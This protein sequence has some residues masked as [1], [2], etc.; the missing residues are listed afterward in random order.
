MKNFLLLTLVVLCIISCVQRPQ[1]AEHRVAISDYSNSEISDKSVLPTLKRV[2]QVKPDT[3]LLP[4]SDVKDVAIDG[5]VCY[6]LDSQSLLTVF[7][8]RDGRIIAQSRPLGR[9]RGEYIS[10]MAIDARND[11][12]YVEDAGKRSIVCY[13]S[14]LCAIGEFPIDEVALDFASVGDGFVMLSLSE[15]QKLQLKLVGET[16][17]MVKAGPEGQ[18][19]ADLLSSVCDCIVRDSEGKVYVRIPMEETIYSLEGDEFVPRWVISYQGER[20]S[21]DFDSGAAMLNSGVH[22][23][24]CFFVRGEDL[25]VSFANKGKLCFCYARADGGEPVTGVEPD[26]GGEIAFCP[27]WQSGNTLISVETDYET[28][29]GWTVC[30]YQFG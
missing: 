4:V 29:G 20:T 13:D 23:T 7:S 28:G 2:L 10:P 6:V 17:S 22:H 18:L 5:E 16:G 19:E 14:T 30:V 15:A 25:L 1:V 8:L 3:A 9:G 27:R 26:D 24:S 21:G 11:T 12:L